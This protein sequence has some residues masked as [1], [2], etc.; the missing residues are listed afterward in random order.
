MAADEGLIDWVTEAM[1]PL[2][3]VTKRAMMGGATLYCDGIIF[4][5]VAS[6]G[7]LWLKADAESDAVWD[8]AGCER[9]T[10]DMGGKTGSMNY[11]R[12]PDDIYDDADE[13]RRWAML[14]LEAGRRAPKKAPPRRTAR[15]ATRGRVSRK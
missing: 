3:R 14:A 11:R 12:A 5:I 7:G 4:A 1:E 2:G 10:Y 9:F 8:E 6:G 13:L 15:A